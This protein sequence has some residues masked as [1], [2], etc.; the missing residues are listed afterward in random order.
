MCGCVELNRVGFEWVYVEHI[1]RTPAQ[2]QSTEQTA[3][4]TQKQRTGVGY[5]DHK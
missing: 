5:V 2:N 4:K 3:K 1:T